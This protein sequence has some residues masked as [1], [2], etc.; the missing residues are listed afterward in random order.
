VLAPGEQPVQAGEVQIDDD[1]RKHIWILLQPGLQSGE[2]RV[3]WRSL[4]AED[5]DTDEGVFSFILD[6]QAAVTSTP[7]GAAAPTKAPAASP[8]LPAL[9]DKPTSVQDTS[10]PAPTVTDSQEGP[11][12]GSCLPGL[13]PVGGL[14]G[15][16]LLYRRRKPMRA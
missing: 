9:V 13:L 16:T 14:V 15:A 5:G 4:S 6:P 7:M 12:G 8:T 10:V 2:Y 1:D 11:G 3:E